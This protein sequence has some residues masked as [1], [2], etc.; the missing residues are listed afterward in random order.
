M[1]RAGA[2]RA[3]S[4]RARRARPDPSGGKPRSSTT[5]R[6]YRP[7][8]PT[9]SAPAPRRRDP[10][11]ASRASRWNARDR[12]RLGRLRHVDQVMRHPLPLLGRRLGRADVH[13]PVHRLESTDTISAPR[14]SARIARLRLPRRGRA[15]QRQRGGSCDRR[16]QPSGR[17]RSEPSPNA[18]SPRRRLAGEM[19]RMRGDDPH[20]EER[21]G[22]RSRPR[23]ARPCS[24]R[25]RPWT[26][27][28]RPVPSTRT[29]TVDPACARIRSSEIALLQRDQPVEPLLD[30]L[31]RHLVVHSRRPAFP[32][33]ASTGTCTPRR[34][35][36]P[37]PPR[38]CPAKSSSVSPGNP[39]MMSV[40][41][42]DL[43]DGLAD[44][45][46]PVEVPL[47]AVRPA[48]S[49][50]GHA[51]RARLE[52]EVDVLAH[53][54]RSRP[55]HRSR[56]GVKS[57]GCGLVNRIRRMPSTSFTARRSSANSGCRDESGTVR[58]RP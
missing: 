7:D 16:A 32:P 6:K 57:C 17:L 40:R 37:R 34:T 36:P 20:V 46:E 56:P 13:P 41:H 38:A 12:E 28:L 42:R 23:S 26:P 21:A 43:R 25:V 10:A 45:F 30:D 55:S 3:A 15:D 29:S 39:T 11:I 47:A 27:P 18:G 50:S 8:P 49:P 52:R 5:A 51:V 9:S 22:A 48:A 19:V 2:D 53:R 35:A 54:A 14:R 4:A 24:S 33:A 58:S 31:L 44:P 1:Q